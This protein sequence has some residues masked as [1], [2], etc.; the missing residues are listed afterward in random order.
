[1][2]VQPASPR[3]LRLGLFVQ[4]LGHHVGGWR[5]EGAKGS[6]TDIDWFTWIARKA[7]EG[8]FDMFFVGD[9]LALSLIHI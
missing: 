8:K 2:S 1:M 4:A 7:E 6:P 3:Q 9:A 5:A